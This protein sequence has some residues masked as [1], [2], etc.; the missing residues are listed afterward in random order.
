MN[1]TIHKHFQLLFIV[2]IL[3]ST[4]S[5]N[6][7]PIYTQEKLHTGWF[8]ELGG[9]DNIMTG[10]AV[11][12]IDENGGISITDKFNVFSEYVGQHWV[13]IDSA[14]RGKEQY[15]KKHVAIY[16][17]FHYSY[18]SDGKELREKGNQIF[19]FPEN[20]TIHILHG[21]A[22]SVEI[23]DHYSE[24]HQN[25]QNTNNTQQNEQNDHQNN[26]QDPCD[27]NARIS[28]EEFV[29]QT[30]LKFK[31]GMV[32]IKPVG[33]DHWVRARNGTILK[34]GDEIKAGESGMATIVLQ[35]TA[36]VRLKRNSKLIIPKPSEA[37]TPKKVSFLKLLWGVL[38]AR[39]R[40]EKNSLKCATPQCVVGVRGTEFE[41]S[42]LNGKSCVKAL[43]HS[44]WFSDLQ[45]RKT[46]IVHEGEKSC[47][48]KNGLPGEP[49]PIGENIN[50]NTS[51]ATN[52]QFSDYINIAGTW[53]TNWGKLV[54]EQHG[55]IVTGNYTHDNGKIT[56]V[57]NGNILTG[58]WSEAPT[59]KPKHD[60]G[61]VRLT[62]SNNGKS[63]TGKWRYGCGGNS[64]P[65]SDWTGTKIHTNPPN[66]HHA[67]SNAI[68][69][70][71]SGTWNTDWGKLVLVQHGNIVTGRYT[72][73]NGKIVGFLKGNILIG[74]WSEAPTYK[75]NHDAGSVVLT[76]SNQG[77]SFSGRWRYGFGGNAWNGTWSGKSAQ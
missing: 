70:K 58:K 59:Y 49:V 60:A 57:L 29:N 71:V 48:M 75:P 52:S 42:Y 44:V 21:A 65:H 15:W 54:L 66:V 39:A 10:Y 37:N 51:E 7:S 62:F 27:I 64:W 73:D 53:N 72:H 36:F 67:N 76:F 50:E 26:G 68:K 20:G 41:V 31:R 34:P 74:K 23:V 61:S 9:L 2:L 56:G 24:S 35:G 45:K 13:T 1:K 22:P 46:V 18:K 43:K 77:K 3:L 12:T 17:T 19:S 4:V 5:A 55:N 69:L 32:R 28:K 25:N 14:F 30:F 33:C 16:A 6:A 8:N 11:L 47:I 40:K 63:F 38:W